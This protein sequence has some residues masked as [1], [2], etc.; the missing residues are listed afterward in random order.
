MVVLLR[1]GGSDLGPG[2][3]TET[4]NG[5]LLWEVGLFLPRGENP[6]EVHSFLPAFLPKENTKLLWG[7]ANEY[8]SMQSLK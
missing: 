4:E 2:L 5:T 7:D 6:A 8:N 3:F 1:S